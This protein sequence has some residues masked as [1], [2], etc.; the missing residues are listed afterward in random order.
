MKDLLNLFNQQR[1]TLDF[2]AIKIALASPDLI[3][4]WSFGEVKKPET[5][6][7]RTFKPE[8]DGLFCA[9][10]FGPVKDYEC[11]CG[12]YKRMKHRGVVCEKCGTEVTL[13]KVR[14]E[15]MGHIDLAS[16]VAHIWF[17]KS[18]PS[19]IGLMLDMTLRDIER[20]LYF[21]AY[22]VTEPG[23]TALE[24]RQLL[25]E[26]QYLTARQEHGDD[27]DAA[28]GAEAV[29]ELLRTIDLQ[30]EMT[31]LREEIAATGSETKLKRLTKRI[32]LIEAFLE[33]GNRP[34]WM[35]M[36]VL[37][38]LPPDLRPLVPLD[39]G[40]FATSDLNDLY[41]RVINRNNR[42]RRLLELSAPDIIVRNEKRM[43][44]ES[45]DALLDNGRRGRAITGTNKRPLKS[46]ADM[47]KG[48]QGRFRQN[49][50]G[51][52][53]DYS[54]RSVIVVGPYLRLHQCGLPKKMALELF[55][56]FVFAKLQ[57]R[58]L[59]TTIKAAKKLVEREEAEVWDILEEVIREHPVMLNRAPTLHR[60]GIQAFEPVLIEGKAIQLHPLVCTAFN[61]DFDGDQMA[62]HV[63]LSLEAQLEARALMMSTNNI[64]SPANGEPI[65]VP[66]QD[67]V[68]GLYYMTRSLE[69]KKGEGMAF[70]NIA[71][72]KRAYD[73][74]VVELHARVKVRITEV[75]TDEEG[76]KQP[77]TS[78]VDTTIGRA[79]LAEILPEGL[80][81]ALANTELTKKNISRLINSSYRQLG[82]KDTVVFADKLM[83]TGF[84]YATRAGVSIGIDDMLIP[85]EKKGILTEAEAEVLEIQEQYQSGLVTAGER[86]NKVVDIW[87]RTNERIAKAMMDTIGTEKVVNA[88]GETIDQKSM[89]SLYIMADSGARGSQA[90]IRQLAGMRGLMARPDGSIIE[91]PIKA[92]F[93]E[94]LNVQE[95]FN[96]T[97]GARKGLADTALK[98]A[99]SGYLTRRLVDVAQDVVITEVDCGTT[100]GL[101]MTPIVEGG[102]V[103]EP[104]KDRVLGRV[105]AEDVFLPGNDE[106][107]IV[108]RNT[109]LDEAWVAKLEDAGVQTIKVR[110]TISCE[111]AFGVCSRCYG[112]DLARGHLVN[113]GEAVGVIA[114]QSIG[115]PGTQL[116]MR[117]FHIGGAAS[118]AAAVDNIT[119]KTTGSVKFSNLKSVEHANGSLV[120]VSRSGE[121]SVLDAHGRERE[122]YKLPYGA[123]IT[124]KDGD[125]IKAGQTVANWDPHNHPIVSEVA[126]FIRFIDFV[127]GITVIEKT[128]ELTG[129]ASREITDP[130]RRGTQ[131]KD[132]RPIVRIVDA[133][134][135][136]LSIPGT[137]LPA[138]YLLPPRS[139]VNLQDGA[140][141]GVGDVVAKIPQEASKTRDI[142]GGLPRVADLFEARKPK[143]PAVLAERS[144]II[145]FGKDTK[146]KQRLI[147][148]DTD[149][150]EHE[151]LI[152]K[153]RQVIVFEG[154][155]VTKGE[156]IVDGE[157]SPQDILRLLGVE[158]LAAYLVKEI[159]DVYRLQGV[160]I[161]DKHIEVITRQMLRKVEIT[162][163]GNSKFLNGE[164]VERQRV[165]EENA[166]LSTRNELP[167]HFDPVLLGITKASLATESFI[168][169]ASFQETTRVLTEAAVRG[170]KD[171]LRGLKENV[172]VGRLIPAGTGLSYHSNRRR[173]ASG[174][175]DSEMQTLAGTP[176]AVEAPAVEAEAEQASG[177][178]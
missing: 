149:G 138:Q 118:R 105:V 89:N 132:L 114:A 117:T 53:V 75:V 11:L 41:R 150:S 68:L 125:A 87:S 156:T 5:I 95:Y 58:G 115:E 4:S 38:V 130:K 153:Y 81:F 35:V 42:L 44:Q 146:G 112:R 172:I 165:I 37:P 136:D 124:S 131:A 168:S 64:L 9:A 28:M 84:A 55:K 175:T 158:P 163:Q 135:N 82:L 129:L 70:A 39:G 86:Y 36:T 73:N 72:V 109:L 27:F 143:D 101:I 110:S 103:V 78:I 43:L 25:T 77:K 157:P 92:N 34:E 104:L 100:E 6:N 18:L 66:S 99:N 144:G 61:A 56:P 74:R 59:A 140:A 33:S 31:R 63:P 113:I 19:R 26:E 2:D 170:T 107:P 12:K 94:G 8:R 50:L 48:K 71:E 173:G 49:L 54:G 164:Q 88:K 91:T 116:T 21:E 90:Q 83:Y 174:L 171:N 93:R 97:H 45:V 60:L 102:D 30:S 10:I 133:K 152:P 119:V 142:T 127:D 177:E 51:K 14:R 159:Q 176:A 169:A 7:Y 17:L 79:L 76:N 69:N 139:I 108:T 85:D 160:K 22:V 67:V 141:V 178:E 120:A 98:T 123:T 106:D 161:N 167:A 24:R 3:R 52:R 137:D 122:R 96:S 111:S 145:S 154:E 16:P 47:I 65:I 1:Q 13:A 57:R 46:L 23:L 32:K 29:Y 20:V 128:D 121:I 134:G 15:R 148:K 162:D 126:G 62:V 155:H 147:I 40:R 166:R 80:P 151:E